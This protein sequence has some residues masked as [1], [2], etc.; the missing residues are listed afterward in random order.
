MFISNILNLLLFSRLIALCGLL[1]L[2]RTMAGNRVYC[3]L[4]PQ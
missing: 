2:L 3:H 1:L 4:E